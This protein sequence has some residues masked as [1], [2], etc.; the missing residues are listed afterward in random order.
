MNKWVTL[1]DEKELSSA[2]SEKFIA[3]RLNYFSCEK[4]YA[5]DVKQKARVK[6]ALDGDENSA[7][8]HV[9]LRGRFKRN[10][11]KVYW[12]MECGLKIQ[13]R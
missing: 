11:L 4:S 1:G 5:Q 3:A 9:I 12:L 13:Q 6:W 2:E 7:F 8:F 10:P